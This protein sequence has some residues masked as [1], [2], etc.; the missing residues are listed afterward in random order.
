LFYFF[1]NNYLSYGLNLIDSLLTFS[2]YDIE[3]NCINFNYNFNNPRIKTKIITTT[4][5]SFFFVTKCKI[6]ATLDSDFDIGV[7]LDADIIATKNIDSIFVDNEERI[8]SCKFPLFGRHPHNPFDRWLHIIRRLTN[9]TP[10]MPWVYSNYM[11]A[12]NHRWFFQ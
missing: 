12:K 7:L 1:D 8:T 4:D 6:I 2:K 5:S 9:K 3:V 11:F 10:K